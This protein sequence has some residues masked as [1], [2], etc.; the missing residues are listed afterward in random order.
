MKVRLKD[1][2]ERAG[3]AVNTASMILN[4][5]PN[6][7]ASKATEER[8]HQAAADL[9]Y[10]PSRA[11]VALRLG[12]FNTIGLV[13]PDLQNPYFSRVA[14]LLETKL[15]AH[16]YDLVIESSQ[17]SV[18]LEV[19][20]LRSILERQVDGAICFLLDNEKHRPLL[21]EQFERG[22]PLLAFEEA[23]G[24]EL[25]VDS[26][27]INFTDGMMETVSH[28]VGH[29]HRRIAFFVAVTEGQPEGERPSAVRRMLSTHG[30][31]EENLMLVRCGP[32]IQNARQAARELFA[33]GDDRPTA[34]V[35]HN[36]LSAV[37]VIR[38][39]ADL[40]L[41]AP[42]DFSVVGVDNTVIGEHLPVA[43]TTVELPDDKMVTEAIALLMRRMESP[44][45][46]G[47]QRTEFS[48][49]LVVREST[50]PIGG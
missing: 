48:S 20:R 8:V 49:R 36:D 7:W 40:G 30:I 17:L 15:E 14:E 31:P 34:V 11:A 5:R 42:R 22:K 46:A 19:K 29:G 41:Q 1:V 10:R 12:K 35:A 23:F 45:Y 32:T 6:S 16:G 4:R 44:K 33:M 18:D 50:G 13:V 37:G 21:V 27:A 9:D 3:V 25:P 2:A 43:L 47:P 38:G 24:P 28:L 39:G 26:V